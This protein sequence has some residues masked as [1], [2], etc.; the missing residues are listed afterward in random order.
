MQRK[1]HLG[2]L[3]NPNTED[4]AFAYGRSDSRNRRKGSMIKVA[5][6]VIAM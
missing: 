2:S 4:S 1:V 5:S 6:V 3:R